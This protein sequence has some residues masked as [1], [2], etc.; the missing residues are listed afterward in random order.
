M[1]TIDDQVEASADDANEI[2]AGSMSVLHIDLILGDKFYTRSGQR[3][4]TLI[5][6]L[7][8]VT[9]TDAFL[10]WRASANDTGSFANTMYGDDR[11]APAE[12]TT[13]EFDISGRAQTAATVAAGS[14]ELGE[15][16]DGQDY[17]LTVTTIIQE[18]VD[19]YDPSAIV[20][21]SINDSGNGERLGK[22]FNTD[23]VLA[24]KLHITYTTGGQVDISPSALAYS[25]T[26]PTPTFSPQIVTMLPAA[27]TVT[28]TI[29]NPVIVA[30]I[31]IEVD[32]LSY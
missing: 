8:G 20:L 15:W 27:V 9:I 25:W 3:F 14:S 2:T 22:S 11:A 21:F 17:T 13:A 16:T 29:P 6:G 31:L 4:A 5:M 1:A 7:S 26:I 30:G 12:F 23:E 18:L 32:A 10:T 24:P 19:S 28:W